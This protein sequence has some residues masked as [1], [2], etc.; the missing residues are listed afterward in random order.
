[1]STVGDNIPHL[2]LGLRLASEETRANLVFKNMQLSVPRSPEH[3]QCT[4]QPEYV[5]DM[6]SQPLRPTAMPSFILHHFDFRIDHY[7]NLASYH[8]HLRI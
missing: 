6:V 3:P 7:R 5:E 8:H 4:L 1:M 2:D